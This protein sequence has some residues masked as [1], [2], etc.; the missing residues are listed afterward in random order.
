MVRS[1]CIAWESTQQRIAALDW[2]LPMPYETS[3][4]PETAAVIGKT[5]EPARKLGSHGKILPLTTITTA[6]NV[7]GGQCTVHSRPPPY[8]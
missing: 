4:V 2:S 6:G 3:P 5:L 7:K 1:A 8:G